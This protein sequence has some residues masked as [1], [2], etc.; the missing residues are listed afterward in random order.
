MKGPRI[1]RAI[2]AVTADMA[3]CGIPK[4]HTNAQDQYR[5]RSIDD[6]L[7]RL[8]PSLAKH[9]LCVLPRV[10]E[11]IAVDRKGE[12]NEHLVSVVLKVAF[13]LVSAADETRHTVEAYGEA[14]DGGDKATS[15]AMSSAFKAAMLLTFCIPLDGSEETDARTFKLRQHDHLPQPADGWEQWANEIMAIIGG[16]ESEEALARVQ[17]RNRALLKAVSRER[18]DLYQGIGKAFGSRRNML[19]SDC[20]AGSEILQAKPAGSRGRNG[21]A[22]ICPEESKPT[23]RVP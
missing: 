21:A 8:A 13:D 19:E 10:I 17:E 9:R 5:Y 14:L 20:G 4:S 3:R 16:C 11:R 7:G 1:Y 23:A 2:N 12:R 22:K 15:K 6:V 18:A